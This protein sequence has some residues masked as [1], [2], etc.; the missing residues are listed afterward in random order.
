M[1]LPHDYV[2]YTKVTWSDASGIEHVLYPMSKTGHHNTIQQ[3]A[4][5]NY[6]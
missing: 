3:D 6:L 4:D 1:I 5:G 2:N